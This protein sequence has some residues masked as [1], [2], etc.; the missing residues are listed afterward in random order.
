MKRPAASM[1]VV[2]GHS[3][4]CVTCGA[5]GRMRRVTVKFPN[6]PKSSVDLVQCVRC[7]RRRK[8][9]SMQQCEDFVDKESGPVTHKL[10]DEYDRNAVE[11]F[12]PYGGVAWRH[13]R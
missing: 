11:S 13:P 1:R 2:E 6:E 4:P 5:P 10:A 12:A 3:G 7:A 9:Q 8:V